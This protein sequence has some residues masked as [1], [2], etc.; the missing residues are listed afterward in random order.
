ML[1]DAFNTPKTSPRRPM[2]AKGPPKTPLWPFKNQRILLKNKHFQSIRL[3]TWLFSLAWR[4]ARSDPPPNWGRRAEWL[5]PGLLV[6]SGVLPEPTFQSQGSGSLS[7]AFPLLNPPPPGRARLH[8]L[9][10]SAALARLGGSWAEKVAFQE[11]F[12]K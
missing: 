5:S 2:T 1:L 7:P 9:R 6:P 4:N 11:A 12:K 8:L 3:P 10:R